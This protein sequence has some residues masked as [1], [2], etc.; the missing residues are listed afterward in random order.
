[1][2]Q[3]TLTHLSE[4][5]TRPVRF[6]PREGHMKDG[7]LQTAVDRLRRAVGASGGRGEDAPL[8][9]RFANERDSAAFEM[10]L[11]RHGP[12][13]RSACRRIL[14][15]EQDAEDAFQAT[16]LAL[17]RS[18]GGIGRGSLAGWLYRA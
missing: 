12:M 13:L 11:I 16:F 4:S 14:R 3:N 7:G 6:S 10:L 8:L 15:H 5:G 2:L 9:A 1:K 17:A 18:A